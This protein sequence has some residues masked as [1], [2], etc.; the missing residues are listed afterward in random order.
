MGYVRDL[1]L[2][3]VE[4]TA[5]RLAI[6][7]PLVL[8]R[9]G[10]AAQHSV[11]PMET[12][13][14]VSLQ[15]PEWRAV[16]TE[17]SPHPV[18][19]R[20]RQEMWV[21]IKTGNSY[22]LVVILVVLDY[23]LVS[24]FSYYPWGGFAIELS[25]GFTFLTVLHIAQSRPVWQVLAGIYLVAISLYAAAVALLPEVTSNVHVPAISGGLLLIVAPIVILR[26]VVRDKVVTAETILGA[27][28]VYLLLGF[29]FASLF[30]T[31]GSLI[32]GP[33]FE[34]Y[35]QASANDYLFFSYTTLTTV[36]YGDLVPVGTLGRTFAM[37]EALAG[38]IYL[39]IVVARLVS[40]WGQN[41]PPRPPRR[42]EHPQA[43]ETKQDLDAST[44]LLERTASAYSTV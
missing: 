39:V 25:L 10:Y 27:I 8:G 1:L 33:F 24:T 42:H 17:Q 32:P 20:R 3:Q 26:R 23:F 7:L 41:F 43:E 35:P 12:P 29:S 19:P 21:R 31:I 6:V 40:L 18:S 16:M 11:L 2:A 37:V 14:L 5:S 38:Q 36:G 15:Q 44:H 34:G 28:S 30:A 13:G 9:K 22:G 4:I